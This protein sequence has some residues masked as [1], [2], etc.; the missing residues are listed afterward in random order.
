MREWW[1][2]MEPMQVPD[3]ERKP[4][5]WWTDMDEVFHLD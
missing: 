5:A 4:G 2:L 1:D 3:P